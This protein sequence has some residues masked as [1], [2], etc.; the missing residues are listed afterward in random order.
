V[1]KLYRKGFTA[2]FLAGTY[3]T[4]TVAVTPTT[5]TGTVSDDDYAAAGAGVWTPVQ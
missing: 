2:A 3:D 4:T 5:G 1:T